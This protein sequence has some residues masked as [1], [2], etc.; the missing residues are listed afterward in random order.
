MKCKALKITHLIINYKKGYC[1]FN[2]L[3]PQ[4]KNSKL[5]HNSVPVILAG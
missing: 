3:R 1:S 2:S 5:L 4:V